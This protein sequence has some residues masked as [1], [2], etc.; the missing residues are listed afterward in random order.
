MEKQAL[1]QPYANTGLDF[2][3]PQDVNK[4][5]KVPPYTSATVPARL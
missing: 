5:I 2:E 1:T 3:R 4:E